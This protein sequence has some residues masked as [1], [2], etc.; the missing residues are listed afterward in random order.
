[1]RKRR[2]ADVVQE[3]GNLQLFPFSG[4]ARRS[5]NGIE[6]ASCHVRDSQG[7]KEAAV[8]TA[9]ESLIGYTELTNVPKPLQLGSVDQLRNEPFVRNLD[10]AVD[11]VPDVVEIHQRLQGVIWALALSRGASGCGPFGGRGI[12]GIR[13][14]PRSI[15]Q[16]SRACT[17]H[18]AGSA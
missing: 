11:R 15:L 5:C 18:L 1:M 14:G 16:R 9:W 12:L 4:V 7:M 2:V 3:R 10:V 17:L 8:F 6:H 13:Y